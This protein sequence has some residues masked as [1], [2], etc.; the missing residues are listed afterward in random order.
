M[1]LNVNFPDREPDEVEG[2][3]V[4]AQG[5]RDADY[6]ARSSTGRT[7]AASPITGSG[8]IATCIPE[9]APILRP[10]AS[11]RISVTPLHLNLTHIETCRKLKLD[12]ES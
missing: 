5:K 1:V 7:R 2:M 10:C 3:E 11:G 4:T 12:F 9:R 6:C 8:S